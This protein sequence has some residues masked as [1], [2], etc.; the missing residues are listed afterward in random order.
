MSANTSDFLQHFKQQDRAEQ[1]DTTY[2]PHS[3]PLHIITHLSLSL[4][5]LTS[6]GA[7]LQH[8]AR[9]LSA[10]AMSPAPPLLLA[11][12]LQARPGQILIEKLRLTKLVVFLCDKANQT[13]SRE[14]SHSPLSDLTV[15][16]L[17][18]GWLLVGSEDRSMLGAAR[19]WD[20]V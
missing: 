1:R 7:F 11:E 2:T 8:Q 12:I 18:A 9:P 17:A 13:Q 15:C 20:I 5:S 16:L 10:S 3:T 6:H 14:Q 19:C 4:F